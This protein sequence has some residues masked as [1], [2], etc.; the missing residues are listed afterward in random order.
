[1]SVSVPDSPRVAIVTGGCGGMG[2][3]IAVRLAESGCRVLT[4]DV[5]DT[6]EAAA[7]RSGRTDI[8]FAAVDVSDRA[9]VE[10]AVGQIAASLGLPTILVNAAGVLSRAPF[11]DLTDADWQRVIDVNLRGT[12]LCGQVV[13][14]GLV[15]AG[16]PGKIVNISSN[17]QV[18]ATPQAAHYAATK[19]GVAS[20]TRTMAL[21]LA[22]HHINVNLV[23]PGPVL[24][25]M[26]RAAFADPEFRAA[27]E[28]TIP[29]GRLGDP[30]DIVGA[31]AFL[32]S[33]DSD[34]V[35]GAALF[36]DG[37]QTLTV[38]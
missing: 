12:F 19:G 3:A 9:A 16:Q 17:S 11:L 28:R 8:G 20:L 37:G 22:P 10:E 35:T 21:E 38:G 2:R 27:R 15:R 26:N 30:A 31:V 5:R 33:A 34:Y 24:T 7:L 32:T 23:C 1:M 25:D 29:W 18:M 6:P 36:V 14:R 4:F 13:A